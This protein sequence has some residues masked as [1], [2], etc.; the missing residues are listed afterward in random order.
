MILSPRSFSCWFCLHHP[1]PL[2]SSCAR[3][4]LPPPDWLPSHPLCHSFHI[5]IR[6]LFS[7]CKPDYVLPLL[8][9]LVVFPLLSLTWTV[10]LGR[11]GLCRSPTTSRICTPSLGSL[12]G[13]H[14]AILLPTTAC[15]SMP[16]PLP[17]LPAILF[18]VLLCC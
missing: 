6:G 12:T 2:P 4:L 11:P 8:I 5:T 9:C 10:K 1:H 15:L 16:G 3:L 7:P 18:L 17:A 14:S 13:L